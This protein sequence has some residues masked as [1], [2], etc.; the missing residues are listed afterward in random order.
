MIVRQFVQPQPAVAVSGRG[1]AL[2]LRANWPQFTLL[3]VVNAFV[4]AM[5]GLERSVLPVI[6]TSEFHV[7]S[8]T[9]VLLFVAT[10]GLAKAITNLASGWLADRHAR[11]RALILGWLIGLPVPM[12]ILTADS[13]WWIVVAN[14]LLGVNQGLTWS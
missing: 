14:A 6:A 11:R 3:V 12:L 5:V 7:V 1:I 2:G 10:F 9:A 4:G 8:T 13:W